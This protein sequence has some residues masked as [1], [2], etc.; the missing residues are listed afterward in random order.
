MGHAGSR[1]KELGVES[2]VKGI[3]ITG[4]YTIGSTDSVE[5]GIGRSKGWEAVCGGNSK[6]TVFS[7]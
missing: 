2:S 6:S 7:L 5:T 4:K 1:S 3:R